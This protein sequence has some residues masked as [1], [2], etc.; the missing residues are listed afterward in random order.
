MNAYLQVTFF[1]FDK[2]KPF[3]RTKLNLIF[4]SLNLL[5]FFEKKFLGVLKAK[6]R[7]KLATKIVES[8]VCFL[9]LFR[10]VFKMEE[11]FFEK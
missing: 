9:K 5:E 10:R 2:I 6:K 4:S 8:F 3:F 7:V 11:I 1:L